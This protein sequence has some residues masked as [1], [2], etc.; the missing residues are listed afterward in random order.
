MNTRAPYD[1]LIGKSQAAIL[2]ELEQLIGAAKI[3]L[4]E[5]GNW[6]VSQHAPKGPVM[7]ERDVSYVYKCVWGEYAAGIDRS[8]VSLLLD[9]LY[10]NALQP[11]GDLFFP[12]EP[13]DHRDD[14]RVY[15][16]LTFLR[17]AALID[18][19]IVRDE[20]ILRRV[21]QYQDPVTGGCFYNI[22]EDPARPQPP[23]FIAIGDTAFFGEFALAAG[24]IDQALKAGAWTLR[25]VQDNRAHMTGEAI[26][27]CTTDRNGDLVTAIKPG[28]RISRTVNNWD[29]NQMGWNIGCAMAFLADLYEALRDK[30][31]YDEGAAYKYLDAVLALAD[32]EDTMPLYTYFYPSKCKVAWGAGALLRVLVKYGLGTEERF[33]KLYRA[34]KQVFTLTF[35]SSQLPDGSWPSLHYPLGDE[36]PELQFDYRVLK[37]LTLYPAER[38]NNKTCSFLPATEI[39]GEFLGEIGAM[40]EGLT[41]LL[42]YYRRNGDDS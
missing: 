20:R 30:C 5:G 36:S 14:T 9:W 15:R 29:A 4:A 35:L 13:P 31:G 34:A 22:G 3:T 38:I 10:Q 6:L 37:G 41:S 42:Q 21:R 12:E 1:T 40:V 28:E 11:N 23:D 26:L 27:Y 17:F 7:R 25:M 18:H 32:F 2:R 16:A 24:W 33:D 19:P 8:Y 39:T